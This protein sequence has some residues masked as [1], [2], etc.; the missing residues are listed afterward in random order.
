MRCVV[1][2]AAGFIGTN[3]SI[4]LSRLGNEVLLIDDLSRVGVRENADLLL[5]NFNLQISQVDVSKYDDFSKIMTEFGQFDVLIH[6]AGQVSLLSS[7][8]NPRRDFEVNALGSLNILE[9]VRLNM[10]NAIVVGMSSNKIYGDLNYIDCLETTKRYTTPNNKYGFNESLQLDFHGPY[11]CSKGTQD[12][13][14]IDYNRIFGIRTVSLRQSTVYGPYQKPVS[15]QG[16][17]AYFLEEAKKS[18]SVQLYGKGK[19]VRDILYIDDLI[20][21]FLKIPNADEK[22]FGRGY[23][24]GG[25]HK[26]SLS[27]LELFDEIK[28]IFNVEVNF[29]EGV[30]RPGD[31]KYFVSD[32]SLVEKTF[33]WS[34]SI[35]VE[36]GLSKVWNEI[37]V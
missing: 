20:D 7:I 6:L 9:F 18:N 4:A 26:N 30:E 25:G 28:R 22:A 31:Q 33:G 14:F 11:G 29:A 15:D 3:L 27:I 37:Q 34:P 12:Q 17:I 1:T 23:N 10:P 24:V 21:L 13:Y 5:K 2:G 32:N 16:W 19:Q 8:E 35:S 36:K